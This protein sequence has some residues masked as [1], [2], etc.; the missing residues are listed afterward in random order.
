VIRSLAIQNFKSFKRS[1]FRLGSFTLLVGANGA[2]KS[3][4]FDALRFLKFV[5]EGTS[6]RDAIEGHLPSASTGPAVSGIRGGASELTNRGEDS[7]EFT[8]KV[9][10]GD[11]TDEITYTVS[12]DARRY[13]VVKE[14]LKAISHP[15]PYVYSTHPTVEPLVQDPASPVLIARFYKQTPGRNPRREF[16]PNESILSQFRGRSAES[17]VNERIADRVRAELSS[18]RPL[19]LRPEVLR[20]YS[21]LGRFELGEHG[22][23]FA[24]AVWALRTEAEEEQRAAGLAAPTKELTK[25]LEDEGSASARWGA[26]RAWL[27]ELTPRPVQD[28]LAEFAPTGEAI[29]AVKEEPFD[30]PLT[31]RSLSDGTLRFA[32]LAVAVWSAEGRQ[33]LLT[34]ELENGIHPARLALLVRMLEQATATSSAVQVIASTHSPTVLDWLS[35]DTLDASLAIGWDADEQCSHVVSLGEAARKGANASTTIGMLQAEGWL[36]MAAD[37]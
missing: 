2:G 15:G 35:Q 30:K 12:V 19:E 20:Q 27:S 3:N 14:E 17:L 7:S 25:E 28:I 33:T 6:I 26:V 10:I 1:E 23:N 8:L 21:P 9:V 37:R 24:A 13:R 32:A 18:I 4:L 11:R 5:G 31:A 34:E 36:R 22:E 16:S 29:V